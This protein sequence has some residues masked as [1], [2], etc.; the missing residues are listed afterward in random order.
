MDKGFIAWCG[1]VSV[2]IRHAELC[3]RLLSLEFDVFVIIQPIYADIYGQFRI[4]IKISPLASQRN[5]T[6][7]DMAKMPIQFL[8]WS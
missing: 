2:V 3:Q 1:E 7:M 5:L 4:T 8:V 6:Q